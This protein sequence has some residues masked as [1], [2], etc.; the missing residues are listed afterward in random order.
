MSLV[1]ALS[2][3]DPIIFFEDTFDR[4]PDAV[5]TLEA[6]HDLT[7][8]DGDT[9]YV[10][11][12]WLAGCSVPDFEAALDA[13]PTVRAVRRVCVVDD[14]TLH[15]VETTSFPPEQSL[16]L[17]TLRAHDATHIGATRDAD[18]LHVRARF[19]DRD[20]LD[21]FVRAAD[22]VARRVD[23]HRLYAEDG[24]AATTHDLT[25]RQRAALEL[26]YER[27]YY[28]TPSEVTLDT[29]AGEFGVTPQT[30]SRHLRVAVEKVVADAVGPETP[31]LQD[32]S[33]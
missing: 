30:L 15:R 29:L 33:Q 2:L 6:V 5:W 18:G 17:P 24:E 20:A 25:D 7:D 10:S 12:W 13:D 4:E 9:Y 31:R 3:S 23:V 19:P 16:L 32:P 14:R 26:A 27:G 1:S 22:D 28:E 21:A 11:F 8:D